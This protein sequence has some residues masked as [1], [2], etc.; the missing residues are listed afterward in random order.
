VDSSK[1]YNT[2]NRTQVM[3]APPGRDA[4]HFDRQTG[5]AARRTS[6]GDSMVSVLIFL[7]RDVTRMDNIGPH[8]LQFV[9]VI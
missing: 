1:L 9:V 5:F 4:T 7:V 8:K 6:R 2:D 3:N